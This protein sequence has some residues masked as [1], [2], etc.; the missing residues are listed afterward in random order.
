MMK[1]PLPVKDGVNATR[2][3]VPLSGP[4]T[5]I[6]EYVLERFGHVDPEGILE[7]FVEGEVA[8]LDGTRVGPDDPL[9][10][11]EFIWYYRSPPAEQPI[12]F[13]VTILHEDE[14]LVVA[15]KPPF[16]PTTPGGRFLQ[17][18]ALVRLRR[19]LDSPD[20]TP[21]H[22]LDRLTWG[23]V[24]F[25]KDAA[26]RGAYQQ[27]FERKEIVKT[28]EAI[29]SAPR[30]ELRE[31]L[32][33]GGVV[34]V[35][36]RLNKIKA[37]LRAFEEDGPINAVSEVRLVRVL[38]GGERALYELRPRTGKTHQLRLHMASLGLAL[39]N[40]PFYPV[41]LDE[42]PDQHDRPL[43]LLARSIRFQDPLTGEDR[44]FTS[45]LDLER[46]DDV[47]RRI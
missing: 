32:A 45:T 2:L 6:L 24:L 18:T 36:N 41:L 15:D 12:P 21:L 22:R 17:E 39:E 38:E 43:K 42:A 1:S 28:Y 13:E 31:R 4:W 26:S 19:L 7:R 10:A 8:A 46:P 11:H 35:Q 14:H 34:V 44:L 47:P 33:D 40:D 37:Q 3:H 5:T 27:L 20:L 30:G 23:V 9:G 25:V 16:L 29:A